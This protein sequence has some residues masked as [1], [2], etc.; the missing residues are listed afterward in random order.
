V[1]MAQR[2]SLDVDRRCERVGARQNQRAGAAFVNEPPPLITP[3]MVSV[4]APLVVTPVAEVIATALA[5]SMPPLR[6]SRPPASKELT[7][8]GQGVCGIPEAGVGVDSQRAGGEQDVTGEGVEAV[9]LKP[10]S[11]RRCRRGGLA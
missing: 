11:R 7:R 8:Q 2:S 3:E 10:L 4:S 9:R 1:A 5:R 6:N